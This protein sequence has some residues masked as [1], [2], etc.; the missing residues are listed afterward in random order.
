[1][2]VTVDGYPLLCGRAVGTLEIVF[3]AAAHLPKT[4]A[5]SRVSVDG[6]SAARATVARG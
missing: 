5:A 3:P 2:N 6:V 1:M 4:I